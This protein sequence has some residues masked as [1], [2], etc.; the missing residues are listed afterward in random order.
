MADQDKKD[1]KFDSRKA[2]DT[3]VERTHDIG[4][5][6]S[7]VV[8]AMTEAGVEYWAGFPRVAGDYWN[9]VT[10][11]LKDG[12]DRRRDEE[13]ADSYTAAT[14][15]LADLSQHTSR[16]YSDWAKLVADSMHRFGEVFD[17]KEGAGKATKAKA[18]A[19]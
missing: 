15:V 13:D 10:D 5:E 7:R 17:E 19:K 4:S 8:R 16:V 2:V 9:D 6:Y 18:A 1:K 12:F 14:G 11:T 3:T